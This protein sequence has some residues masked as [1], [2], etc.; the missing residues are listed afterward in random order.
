MIL[1]RWSASLRSSR[2]RA[3]PRATAACAANR[4]ASCTASGSMSSL[5]VAHMWGLDD[6]FTVEAVDARTFAE[7]VLQL[8]Q[9]PDELPGWGLGLDTAFPVQQGDADLVETGEATPGATSTIEASVSSRPA[10]RFM[11]RAA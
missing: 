4:S 7:L 10:R 5:V 9:R 3:C 8:V 6:G 11:P 1:R 2:S